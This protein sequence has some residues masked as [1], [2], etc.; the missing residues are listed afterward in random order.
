[1]GIGHKYDHFRELVQPAMKSKLEEFELLG[2]GTVL[3]ETLWK[4]LTN[5]RW[6]KPKEEIKLFE[7]VQD[8]LSV[9]VGEYMSFVT[10]EAFKESEFYFVS[11]DDLK[12]LLK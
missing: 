5:K 12:E 10:V 6:K 9:D 2:Y 7:I 4:Y 3:E 8:I 11:G 1:M